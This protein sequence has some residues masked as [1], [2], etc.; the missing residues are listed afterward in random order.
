MILP[1]QLRQAVIRPAIKAI[2]L[3]SQDA[4]ELLMATAAQETQLGTYIVQEGEHGIFMNGGLGIFQME[5]PTHDDLWARVIPSDMAEEIMLY[6]NFKNKP[7]AERMITDLGYAAI[8]CRIKYHSIP[9]PLPPAND[10]EVM[11]AYWKKYYNTP[12][13]AGTEKEFVE[14]YRKLIG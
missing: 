13:G 12:L 10:V 5:K 7:N 3:W 4:E 6:C 9:A 11:A 2:N 14:N 8:M 1:I